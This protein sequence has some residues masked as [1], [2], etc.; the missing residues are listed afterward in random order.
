MIISLYNCSDCN[1]RIQFVQTYGKT[2]RW[3]CPGCGSLNGSIKEV[4]NQELDS[5]AE[6]LHPVYKELLSEIIDEE[7]REEMDKTIDEEWNE[8]EDDE[9]A[10][11]LA[12][13]GIGFSKKSSMPSSPPKR[14]ILCHG[15][16]DPPINDTAWNNANVETLD[17][18]PTK[19]ATYTGS[20]DVLWPINAS[21]YDKFDE[22]MIKNCNINALFNQVPENT[23]IPVD[24]Y[25][26]TE[27]EDD[28]ENNWWADQEGTVALQPKDTAWYNITRLLKDGGKLYHN[29]FNEAYTHLH[30]VE[31]DDDVDVINAINNTLKGTGMYYKE[32]PDDTVKIGDDYF[33]VYTKHTIDVSKFLNFST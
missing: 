30:P 16:T 1:D 7:Q 11:Q 33:L 32:D 10:D 18:D 17:N 21:L 20:I 4:S 29:H 23:F 13:L 6:E 12:G 31:D 27:E 28:Q 3:T 26:L 14:H 25:N 19:H 8:I 22:V 24:P 5:I 9:L 15:T 2:P